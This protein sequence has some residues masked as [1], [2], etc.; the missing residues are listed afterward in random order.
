MNYRR[1]TMGR[2][3]INR[4]VPRLTLA[5]PNESF[6]NST[7]EHPPTMN[8]GTQDGPSCRISSGNLLSSI[9]CKQIQPINDIGKRIRSLR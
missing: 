4:N 5:E 9:F 2:Q 3:S 1:G 8:G 6:N 7:H